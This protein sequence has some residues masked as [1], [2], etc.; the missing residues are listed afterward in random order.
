MPACLQRFIFYDGEKVKKILNRTLQSKNAI[1]NNFFMFFVK[2]SKNA[3]NENE[4]FVEEFLQTLAL[5]RNYNCFKIN[6]CYN[7]F[8]P[9]TIFN[10]FIVTSAWKRALLPSYKNENLSC[11]CIDF[12][13]I[14]CDEI[15]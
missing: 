5:K 7:F 13:I 8:F 4:R 10:L 9:S 14:L 3:T 12:A 15:F 1:F 11:F 2:H 6:C